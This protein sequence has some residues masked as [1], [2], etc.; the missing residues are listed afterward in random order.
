MELQNKSITRPITMTL[1]TGREIDIFN[2]KPEDIDIEDIAHALSNLCRYGGHCLFHYSVA[3]HSYLCSLEPGTKSEQ[4]AFLLHDASE[5]YVNDLVRPIKYRQELEKYREI[6]DEIQAK[7]FHRFNL[8][9]PYSESVHEV[10]DRVLVNEIEH[11]I[12]LNHEI[13][14]KSEETGLSFKEARD[15]LAQEKLAN[16]KFPKITPEEAKNLF[17]NRFYELTK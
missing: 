1:H 14:K 13:T 10:D 7:I 12:I 11:L 6:E 5:A 16:C 8:P 2:L 3:L 4:L 17:L 9:Y 15:L